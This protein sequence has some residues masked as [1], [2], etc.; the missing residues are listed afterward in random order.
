VLLLIAIGLRDGGFRFWTDRC[1]TLK[2]G[3]SVLAC[4]FG[5]LLLAAVLRC[6]PKFIFALCNNRWLR[7]AGKYSYCMY[8]V[9]L[10]V[11]DHLAQPLLDWVMLQRGGI[12]AGLVSFFLVLSFSVVIALVS[13]RFY[14]EP[15]L[16]LKQY[17]QVHVVDPALQGAVTLIV[18]EALAK[19]AQ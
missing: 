18:P 5:A 17:Y 12:T 19:V 15:F 14:E 7:L 13:W 1:W 4:F 3:P 6:G 10:P 9:H 2:F 16:R 11:A 8:V